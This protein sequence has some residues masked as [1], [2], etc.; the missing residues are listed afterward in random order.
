MTTPKK[1]YG[2]YRPHRANP[3]DGRMVDH[4]TG[5]ITYPPSR[6]KQSFIPECDIN[7]IVKS[8]RLTGQINHMRSNA[9]QGVYE[10]LPDPLDFQ[11]SL[12]I[13]QEAR[14]S[15]DSLPAQVRKRFDY[16]PGQ[17]LAFMSDPKNQDEI[18]KMGLAVDTRP[19]LAPLLAPEPA[20]QAPPEPKNTP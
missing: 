19:P 5:E 6:T 8:Y 17:F 12:N 14:D 2:F 13:M 20:P 16:D 1:L 9:A 11:Q 18:I 3:E 4:K 15:F 10:D 7:N